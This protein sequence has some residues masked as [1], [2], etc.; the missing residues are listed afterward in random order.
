[1]LN[2]EENLMPDFLDKTPTVDDVLRE[3]SRLRSIVTEAVDDGVSSALRA[4]K[5]SR[6][7]ADDAIHDARRTVKQQ[8]LQSMGIVFAVGVMTGA[9][10]AWIGSRR[11]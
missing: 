3:V 10:A 5:Q 7:T 8:P 2:E 1:M 11:S 4:I 6:D 9:L